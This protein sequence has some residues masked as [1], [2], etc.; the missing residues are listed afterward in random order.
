[1]YNCI[2][3]FQWISNKRFVWLN[4]FFHFHKYVHKSSDLY[5]NY[6]M[7][8]RINWN[9]WRGKK[10]TRLAIVLVIVIGAI[11]PYKTGNRQNS[12]R[13][14]KLFCTG[15]NKNDKISNRIECFMTF[16]YILIIFLLDFFLLNMFV[17]CYYYYLL[18][19]IHNNFQYKLL[20]SCFPPFPV[21]LTLLGGVCNLWHSKVYFFFTSKVVKEW[22]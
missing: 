21:I 17:T 16:S 8:D 11:A 9:Q 12:C 19:N 15:F 6:K 14:K 7:G 5:L 22:R 18:Y 1:M 4:F 13:K 10:S 2:R 3:V 20:Q